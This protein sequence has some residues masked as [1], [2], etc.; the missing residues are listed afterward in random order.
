[1]GRELSGHNQE[2]LIVDHNREHCRRMPG[3]VN[4]KLLFVDFGKELEHNSSYKKSKLIYPSISNSAYFFQYQSK[5]VTTVTLCIPLF[6]IILD[7]CSTSSCPG[8][9]IIVVRKASYVHVESL[10][11]YI[12]RFI[13]F[14]I[15]IYWPYTSRLGRDKTIGSLW[16][17]CSVLCIVNYVHLFD[18]ITRWQ[19]TYDD[20]ICKIT[21]PVF[22]F[23]VNPASWNTIL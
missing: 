1:M 5:V 23:L 15:Y 6:Y 10:L 16:Y 19:Y 3:Y 14:C 13:Y 4:I 7:Y 18:C 20:G 12:I 9:L 11:P 21:S 17:S 22:Y 2:S 8:L